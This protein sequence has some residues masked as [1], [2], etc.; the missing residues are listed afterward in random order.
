MVVWTDHGRRL[1]WTSQTF[2]ICGCFVFN[3]GL[4]K[5]SWSLFDRNGKFLKKTYFTPKKCP[6]FTQ[7]SIWWQFPA[8]SAPRTWSWVAWPWPDLLRKTLFCV[9]SKIFQKSSTTNSC[10]PSVGC[11]RSRSSFT[12]R[13]TEFFAKSVTTK[14]FSNR[15]RP[16]NRYKFVCTKMSFWF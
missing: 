2:E 4:K 14:N 1:P 12:R 6:A 13:T 11:P 9:K 3:V 15:H 5:I 10:A 8:S 16:Q 7:R